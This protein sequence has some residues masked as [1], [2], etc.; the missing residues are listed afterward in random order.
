MFEEQAL[1][2]TLSDP[3][4]HFLV[5]TFFFFAIDR[6]LSKLNRRFLGD[7]VDNK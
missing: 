1:D 2:E 3:I 6:I 4:V 5:H 7:G